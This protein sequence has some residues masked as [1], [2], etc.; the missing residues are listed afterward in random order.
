[1]IRPRVWAWLALVAVIG[2]VVVLAARA[3]GRTWPWSSHA[4]PKPGMVLIPAG[5]FVMGSDKV[6]PHP[7]KGFV[8]LKPLYV[9]EHPARK[10]SLAAFWIDRYEVTN[11]QYREFVQ[12]RRVVAPPFWENDQYPEGAAE[13][14][15]T[16]VRWDQARAFCQWKDKRLPSEAEW[17]KAAR[18][19]DGREFPWGEAFDVTLANTG[20]GGDRKALAPVGSYE[21]GKSPYGVYD[22]IGNVW[23]WVDDWYGP[24]PGNTASSDHYGE[25]FKVVR[26]GG[27]EGIHHD[28]PTQYRAAYRFFAPPQVGL[29]DGGFR[30]A[31]DARKRK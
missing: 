17:E 7:P 6:D 16:Q 19:S 20:M 13:Q 21:G 10:V 24:Y 1:M 15:V 22:M 14:P 23:E 8:M 9:D 4:I 18:G 2:V 30:C 11:A 26:G 12:A 31:K 27:W 28:S 25:K 5:E 29:A 3:T